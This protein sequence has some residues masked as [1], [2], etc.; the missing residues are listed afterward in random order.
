M[1]EIDYLKHFPQH[2]ETV[3]R[4]IYDEWTRVTRPNLASQIEETTRWL[5]DDGVPTCLIALEGSECVGTVSLFEDDLPS[6]PD[7]WPW[8]A[9]LYVDP[10]K[11]GRGIG[12]ALH[13]E[14][15]A[16]ARG[17]GIRRL[18]LHTETAADFYRGR[19]WRFLFAT[20]NDRGED[21]EVFTLDLEN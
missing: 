14:I 10:A 1:P 21:T 2:V 13:D 3:S 17:F 8:F 19:N 11:R 16:T 9:A 6:R 5:N 20:V 12:G 4:W 7:L 15:V 18:Y